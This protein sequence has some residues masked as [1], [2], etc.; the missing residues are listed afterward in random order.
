MATERIGQAVIHRYLDSRQVMRLAAGD[1]TPIRHA[2]D[3]HVRRWELPQDEVGSRLVHDGLAAMA[4][5]LAIRPADET[6]GV[7]L[8]FRT[9]PLNVFLTGNAGA[10][11]VTGRVFT[12]D[13]QTAG[14]SR[15]FVQSYRPTTGQIQSAMDMEGLDVLRIFEDYYARSEQAPT[16]FLSLP[17]G[18]FLMAQ[19]LP[20]GS[21]AE[22]AA[23]TPESAAA[24]LDGG[25]HHLAEQPVRFR[26]GCN[27]DK[28]L[29]AM[30]LIFDGKDAELFRGESGVEVF[31]PRCGARW[32]I[33]RSAYEKGPP[34]AK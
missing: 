12:E 27:R 19:A 32:W 14:A 10:I 26:C 13:V 11:T 34:P 17:D 7:T 1:F 3:E 6:A 4:L 18:R 16:R 8:N 28:I 20:E 24:L 21:P 31:C 22:V 25:L 29:A 30:R 2:Y 33:E 23:L 15:M 9:P 5:H